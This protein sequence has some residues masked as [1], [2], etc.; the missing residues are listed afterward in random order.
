MGISSVS[1][2]TC[3]YVQKMKLVQIKFM[4]LSLYSIVNS[5]VVCL[6]VLFLFQYHHIYLLLTLRPYSCTGYCHAYLLH[7]RSQHINTKCKYHCTTEC[8]IK[9]NL[10]LLCMTDECILFFCTFDNSYHFCLHIFLESVFK[11]L[12]THL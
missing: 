9:H 10:Y 5:F 1:M 4:N 12:F 2:I 7:Q 6:I 8:K 11:V 3:L